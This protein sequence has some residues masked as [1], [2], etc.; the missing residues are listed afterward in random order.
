[1]KGTYLITTNEFF[2]GPNGESY[3][4]VFGNVEVLTDD[5]IMGIKTNAR[6]A[7]WYAKVGTEENHIIIAGCQIHYCIKCDPDSINRDQTISTYVD[8]KLQTQTNRILYLHDK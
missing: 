4:S 1:M 7:N 6:S 3:R 8:D 2:I 5:T